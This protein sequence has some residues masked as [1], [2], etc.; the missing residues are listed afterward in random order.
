LLRKT[1]FVKGVEKQIKDGHGSE[2]IVPVLILLAICIVLL[3]L[4]MFCFY[5]FFVIPAWSYRLL[6]ATVFPMIERPVT[7]PRQFVVVPQPGPY[8]VEV[9]PNHVVVGVPNQQSM[10]DVEIAPYQPGQIGFVTSVMAPAP[11]NPVP[12]GLQSNNSNT[13]VPPAQYPIVHQ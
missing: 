6:D 13:Y 8:V 2:I 7:Q 11:Q 1:N 4:L 9:P 12:Y 10:Y 5:L 3:L